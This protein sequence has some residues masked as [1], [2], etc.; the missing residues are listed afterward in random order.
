MTKGQEMQSS[1]RRYQLLFGPI[2][3]MDEDGGASSAWRANTLKFT[4]QNIVFKIVSL[5]I[6]LCVAN[7]RYESMILG[8]ILA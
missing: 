1:L 8:E 2:V 7:V 4:R 3:S 5:L 6:V